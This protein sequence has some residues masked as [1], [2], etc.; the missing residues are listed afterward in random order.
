MTRALRLLRW[1]EDAI[2]AILLTLMIGL[3]ALQIVLRNLFDTGLGWA[4]PLL[5]VAVLWVGLLG[6]M[7]ATRDDRQISID[8]LSRFLPD[9]W[10]PRVRVL[11]DAFTAAVAAFFAWQAGR[12]VLE[13]HASGMIAFTGVPVWLCEIILPVAVGIIALRYAIMTWSHLREALGRGASP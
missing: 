6:A 4:D 1:C 8:A 11:T 12:L 7:A 13:D 2:L 5:R 3:A 9:H 10:K